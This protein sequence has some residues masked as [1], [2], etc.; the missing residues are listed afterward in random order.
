MPTCCS[1]T[2]ACMA[3]GLGLVAARRQWRLTMLVV[4]A[5]YFGVG[6]RGRRGRRPIP[7]GC[8]CT[9][10][11]GGAAGLYVGLSERWWETR[12]LDLHRRLGP[13]GGGEP[14]AW[15]LTGRCSPPGWCLSAPVWWHALRQPEGAAAPSR[16]RAGPAGMVARARRSTSSPLRS[17]S[18]GRSTASRPTGSIAS[19]ASSRLLVAIPY[20]LAGYV[21][22]RP[23]VRLGR[24][25][26]GGDRRAGS[27]GSGTAETWALLGSRWS[28]PRSIIVL[29]R[30]DGRW[31]AVSRWPRR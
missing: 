2:C 19:P 21:R 4:A 1:S 17:S 3:A 25:C 15:S 14:S 5:S 11:L 20:L 12:F 24:R 10:W 28:G 8:S 7:G 16:V 26:R 29:D 6:H 18:A 22:P 27:S 9:A 23:A 31:Y 30:T 13:A